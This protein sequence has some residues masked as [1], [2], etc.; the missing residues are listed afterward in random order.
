MSDEQV[1]ICPTANGCVYKAICDHAE[2][3]YYMDCEAVKTCPICVLV[4][5]DRCN[6][7]CMMPCFRHV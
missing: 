4:G 2:P 6:R 7:E 5:E 1:F 3:H